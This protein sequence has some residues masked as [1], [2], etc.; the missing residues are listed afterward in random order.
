MFGEVD[1]VCLIVNIEVMEAGERWQFYP[2][3]LDWYKKKQN[4]AYN[5]NVLI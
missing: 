1:T 4:Y 2:Q 5:L 3:Y